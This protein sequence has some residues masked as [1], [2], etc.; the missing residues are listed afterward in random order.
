MVMNAERLEAEASYTSP[1]VC[2]L[3][4]ISYRQLDHWV[5]LGHVPGMTK[6]DVAPGSGFRRRFSQ[7]QMDALRD[8][9][10]AYELKNAPVD[11]VLRYIQA[12]DQGACVVPQAS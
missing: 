1:E 3:T 4:G 11:E 5:R 7:E 6:D 2:A 8:L 10:R 9:K 12:C